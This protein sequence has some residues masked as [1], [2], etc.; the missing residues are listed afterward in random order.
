MIVSSEEKPINKIFISSMM[1][2]PNI[3]MCLRPVDLIISKN[4]K[5]INW[6]VINNFII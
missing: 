5:I 1:V 4:G 6:M 3:S 2:I